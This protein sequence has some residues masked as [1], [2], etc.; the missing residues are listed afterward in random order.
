MVATTLSILFSQVYEIEN[1][2]VV[3]IETKALYRVLA[4]DCVLLKPPFH[5]LPT[6]RI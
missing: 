1:K 6:K 4:R 5:F 3:E 2:E